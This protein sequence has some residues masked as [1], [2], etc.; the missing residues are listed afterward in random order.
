MFCS[1]CGAQMPQ[2]SSFCTSCGTA[3]STAPQAQ[4]QQA[5]PVQ[6]APQYI[7]SQPS[8][9]ASNTPAVAAKQ[10]ANKKLL[11]MIAGGA[12]VVA[13]IVIALVLLLGG[14]RIVGTW[15]LV[16]E[17]EY[18]NGRL[19]WRWDAPTWEN[20]HVTFNRNGTGVWV[21]GNWSE[22]FRWSTS[23]NRLT[24]TDEWSSSTQEFRI[25]GNELRLIQIEHDSWWDETWEIHMILHRR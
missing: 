11:M 13:G 20:S 4:P 25:S 12:V 15:Q 3:F 8:P 19:D 23:G 7:P 21:D 17:E 1:K 24:I 6:P 2:G 10:P 9:A 14:G 18:V 5:Q 22:A 16:A